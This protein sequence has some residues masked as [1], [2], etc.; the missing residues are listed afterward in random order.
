MD[1]HDEKN[2]ITIPGSIVGTLNYTHPI[3]MPRFAL[4]GEI[5]DIPMNQIVQD[6][7]VMTLSRTGLKLL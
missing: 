5:T 4:P 1:S 2:D 7:S 3:L 6:L